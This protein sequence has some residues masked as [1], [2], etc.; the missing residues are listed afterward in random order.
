MQD[1][2]AQALSFPHKYVNALGSLV[3]LPAQELKLVIIIMCHCLGENESCY[4]SISRLCRYMKL[5]RRQVEYLLSKL[6]G[7]K[8]LQCANRPGKSSIYFLTLDAIPM[9]SSAQVKADPC[10]PMHTTCAIDCTSPVQSSAPIIKKKELRER[11][12][13]HSKE[14]RTKKAGKN[15]TDSKEPTPAQTL[16]ARFCEYHKEMFGRTYRVSKKEAGQVKLALRDY[17]LADIETCNSL[18]WQDND[19]WLNGGKRTIA[20]FLSRLNQYMQ[21]L[22]SRREA[23]YSTCI[24]KTP[25]RKP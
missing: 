2:K 13:P 19:P 22:P 4:P 16:I 18:F 25:M 24:S 5:K 10:N 14:S 12:L 23:P 8:L 6:E 7:K 21:Q 11:K 9:Q 1:N 15:A 3:D 17:S 20:I